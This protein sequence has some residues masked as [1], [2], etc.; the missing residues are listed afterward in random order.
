[1]KGINTESYA[2]ICMYIFI[3]CGS[4]TLAA[5]VL[6]CQAYTTTPNHIVTD[7]FLYMYVHVGC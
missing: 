6:L 3:L 1:M 7:I 5:D 2:C 4:S